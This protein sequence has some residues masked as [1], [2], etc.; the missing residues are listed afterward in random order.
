MDISA[1]YSG[2]GNGNIDRTIKQIRKKSF[3]SLSR[4][5]DHTDSK[6][7]LCGICLI[8]ILVIVNM[9][10]TLSALTSQNTIPASG[11]ISSPTPTT[12]AL[13]TDGP[14][15]KNS[16]NQTAY[17]RGVNWLQCGFTISCTGSWYR[18]GDWIWG[19]AITS[20]DTTGL[21]Q[22]LTEMQN[23]GFNALRLCVENSW[24]L[25]DMSTNM[26]GNPTTI[27]CR[28][29][30]LQ[31]IRAAA[32]HGIYCILDFGWANAFS[33]TSSYVSAWTQ[34]ANAYKNEPNVLF[35]LW[36]EPVIT[37][38]T[39]ETATQQACAAIRGTGAEN[40][41]L[42]QYGYCGSFDFVDDI[43]PLV[44]QYGGIV[45][46]NHIYRYPPGATFSTSDS[47]TVSAIDSKL[48]NT[49]SYNSVIGKYPMFIGEF[50]AWTDAGSAERTWCTNLLTVLNSYGAGYTYWAMGQPGSGW[51]MQSDAGSAPYPLNAMGQ[52]LVNAI[53]SG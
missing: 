3:I 7:L 14:F 40:L 42:I 39:W 32:Q 44:Q 33:S 4:M 49:W 35:E 19:T 5:L 18:N 48:R 43:A 23:Y 41:I 2:F 8:L 28:T 50:G 15:I 10:L 26:F 37:Y 1:T 9:P 27:S 52:A 13:H 51:D 47:T 34:I 36:G 38:S 21:N 30:L 29:A 31:T 6:L 12:M 16:L 22:R 25:N 17:L 45:Y 20:L 11:I 24:W 53:A 46:S